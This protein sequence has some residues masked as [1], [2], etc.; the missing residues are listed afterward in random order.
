MCLALRA[1]GYSGKQ[2]LK[3]SE[4]R[5]KTR[6]KWSIDVMFLKFMNCLGTRRQQAHNIS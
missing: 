5:A 4:G 1:A 6:K 3:L 2:L